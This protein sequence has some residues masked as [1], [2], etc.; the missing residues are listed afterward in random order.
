MKQQIIKSYHAVSFHDRSIKLIATVNFISYNLISSPS[1]NNSQLKIFHIFLPYCIR[2]MKSYQ[3]G[4]NG[5]ITC[6]QNFCKYGYIISKILKLNHMNPS[7][8][9]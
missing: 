3:K 5:S 1:T 8:F 2:L 6:D 7:I 9:V 4:T